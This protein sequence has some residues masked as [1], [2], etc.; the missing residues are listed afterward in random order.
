[1]RT[2]GL[3]TLLALTGC[4]P[5]GIGRVSGK[6]TLDGS[7]VGQ[8]TVLFQPTG[9][10]PSYGKTDAGGNYSLNYEPRVQGALV[11]E[12]SVQIRTGWKDM[13]YET[14]KVKGQPETIPQRY[15]DK[16]ELKSTVKE[17]RNTI[18]FDL[19]SK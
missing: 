18:D 10:R 2:I 17:G 7:P 16:S 4:G 6:V 9:G 12:H 11:G 13:D 1:M 3:L 5:S 14:G 8:A 19:K 15:N